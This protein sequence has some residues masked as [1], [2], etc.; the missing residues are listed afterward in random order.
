[1][2]APALTSLYSFHGPDGGDPTDGVFIDAAGDLFG[3]THSG[4][5]NNLGTVFEIPASGAS[6]GGAGTLVNFSSQTGT[7]PDAGLISDA[8]G[9]LFGTTHDGGANGGGTVFEIVRTSGIYLS[10][11]VTLISFTAGSGPVGGLIA[12][13]AGNLLGT[14]A[15]GGSGNGTVFELA[16]TATGYSS[17]LTPLVSFNGT[18]GSTPN[19]GLFIDVGGNL[20]GTT[21]GG[22][23]N[24]N[25]TV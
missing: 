20:I 19:G 5:A 16:K 25:G 8:A 12:D 21:L 1:M 6:Y 3:T 2:S 7:H 24:P 23:V 15:G 13:S 11:P 18:N 9:D 4:G 14:T 17:K 22:G 10:N